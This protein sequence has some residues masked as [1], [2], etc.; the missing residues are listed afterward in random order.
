MTPP[1]ESHSV[2]MTHD[3]SRDVKLTYTLLTKHVTSCYDPHNDSF[4]HP[5]SHYESRSLYNMNVYR[6][7]FWYSILTQYYAAE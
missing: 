6:N 4:G 5:T 3:V 2:T 7:W 1:Y